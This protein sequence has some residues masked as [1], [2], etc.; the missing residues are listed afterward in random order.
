MFFLA[1]ML[2]RG[3]ISAVKSNCPSFWAQSNFLP[4]GGDFY[5]RRRR[6]VYGVRPADDV[7]PGLPG[8]LLYARNLTLVSEITEAN[9]AD[10]ELTEIRMRA[11]ADLAAIVSSGGELLIFLLFQNHSFL[12]HRL[13]P[14]DYFANG[15]PN[16]VSSSRASSSVFAVVTKQM[17]IPRIF[18]TL[19]YS[20]S[21][22]I[23][24]SFRPSA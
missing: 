21:G 10:T 1:A 16:R 12:C 4:I 7:I 23:S 24:C 5:C 19:S 2:L 6:S 11:S 13:L 17:S 20:I 15:A 3:G 9:A 8:S 22:K 14:P 18:S